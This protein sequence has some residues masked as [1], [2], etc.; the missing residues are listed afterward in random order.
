M[1]EYVEKLV[2][3]FAVEDNA[4]SLLNL[5]KTTH[6]D[7][8]LEAIEDIRLSVC[9]GVQIRVGEQFDKISMYVQSE[10]SLLH[11]QMGATMSLKLGRYTYIL[12]K[13][14]KPVIQIHIIHTRPW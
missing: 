10:W 11:S 8:L 14:L 4:I 7:V 1:F 5:W 3:R 6:N 13:L 9:R 2:F 12:E